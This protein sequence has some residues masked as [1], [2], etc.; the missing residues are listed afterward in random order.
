MRFDL[1]RSRP[2]GDNVEDTSPSEHSGLLVGLGEDLS[3]KDSMTPASNPVGSNYQSIM[4]SNLDIEEAEQELLSNIEAQ[5]QRTSTTADG[6]RPAIRNER[7]PLGVAALG[8]AF[9]N[10]TDDNDRGAKSRMIPIQS[11]SKRRPTLKNLAHK[12]IQRQRVQKIVKSM[13]HHAG[14]ESNTDETANE[15][16]RSN[17]GHRRAQTLL[18]S[19]DQVGVLKGDNPDKAMEG[20]SD[21]FL[22]DFTS[23]IFATHI[24]PSASSE[25]P[26]VSHRRTQSQDYSG[27]NFLLGEEDDIDVFA[28]E[29][30]PSSQHPLLG[31]EARVPSATE[32]VLERRRLMKRLER[33]GLQWKNCCLF[34]LDCLHPISIWSNFIHVIF[35]SAI[36]AVLFLCSVAWVLYYY[37]NNPEIDFMPGTATVSWWLNFAGR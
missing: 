15:A 35:H 19:I 29:T 10:D 16:S 1:I 4:K 9:G 2:K 36:L 32:T 23:D 25:I 20:P 34:A 6:F 7:P 11:D 26:K 13:R 17:K 21:P 3:A 33:T 5:S 24:D 18:A 22:V 28:E 14:V 37:F 12:T 30:V 8:L 27:L 31:P